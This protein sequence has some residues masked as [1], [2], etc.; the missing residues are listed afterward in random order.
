MSIEREYGQ[1]ILSCDKCFETVD[2]ADFGDA[3]DYVKENK[4]KTKKS[5]DGEWI[6]ECAN[7]LVQ[8]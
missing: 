8:K 3:L 5:K 4:W 6:H 7:C 1:T 2:C